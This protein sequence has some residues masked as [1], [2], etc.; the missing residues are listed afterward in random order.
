M[1]TDKKR[2][3]ELASNFGDIEVRRKLIAEFGDSNTA[4]EG[5]NQDGE[6]VMISIA[7]TGIIERVWQNNG[8]MRVDE[9]DENGY[10]VGQTYEDD[11][12]E[13][14]NATDTVEARK[15]VES[16]MNQSKKKN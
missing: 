6:D 10:H 7:K 11:C 2:L 13:R 1:A 3:N 9:Y 15:V 12:D 5:T 4:F 8:F 14:A 16:H